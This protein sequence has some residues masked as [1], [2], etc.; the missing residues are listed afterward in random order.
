[1]NTR[2]DYAA[3]FYAG[4]EILLN[5]PEAV[6]WQHSV[7]GNERQFCWLEKQVDREIDFWPNETTALFFLFL[8]A[9]LEAGDL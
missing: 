6:W 8:A 3:Q 9:A 7:S 4:A 2:K 1:M 5:N